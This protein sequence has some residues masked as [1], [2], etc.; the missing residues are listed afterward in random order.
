MLRQQFGAIQQC[1]L[2]A[3]GEKMLDDFLVFL[4]QKT[5]CGINEPT[6]GL[7]QERR[8]REDRRLLVLEFFD[9]L[10]RLAPFQIGIAAQRPQAAAGS[11]YQDAID[12]SSQTFHLKV[13]FA[14]D[15]LRKKI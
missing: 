10:Q 4:R 7:K 11:V 14:G 1:E 6:A 13:F 8:R 2:G 5:A 15:Q 3:V 9:A 12:L